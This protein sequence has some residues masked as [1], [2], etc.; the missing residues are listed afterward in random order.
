MAKFINWETCPNPD[1]TY[2][3][4]SVEVGAEGGYLCYPLEV[5]ILPS[6]TGIS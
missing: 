6:N 1:L 2:P 4:P 5:L 3:G